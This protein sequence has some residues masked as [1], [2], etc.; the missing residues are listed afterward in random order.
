M[1]YVVFFRHISCGIRRGRETPQEKKNLKQ[2]KEVMD[3][4][5]IKH[6]GKWRPFNRAINPGEDLS[7]DG[8]KKDTWLRSGHI[9][10][11][12]STEKR[13]KQYMGIPQNRKKQEIVQGYYKPSYYKQT[14][15]KG[16]GTR[17][18]VKQEM[19]KRKYVPPKDVYI[20]KRQKLK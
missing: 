17:H 14:D 15:L 5:P 6:S 8:I 11:R 3:N 16:N 2:N 10:G 4:I 7:K 1:F 9:K 18:Y 12:P 13:Y 19:P 20:T